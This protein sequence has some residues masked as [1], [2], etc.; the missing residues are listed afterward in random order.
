MHLSNTIITPLDALVTQP[1]Q[2][3]P[4]IL[5][6]MFFFL[7]KWEHRCEEGIKKIIL[8]DIIPSL[9]VFFFLYHLPLCDFHPTHFSLSSFSSRS[10][11]LFCHFLPPPPVSQLV[12]Y[13]CMSNTGR[14][15]PL[16]FFVLLRRSALFF[17]A[18][19]T[20]ERDNPLPLELIIRPF[21]SGPRWLA[22]YVK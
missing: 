20:G 8:A 2:T 12:P 3:S 10:L 11:L 9:W 6:C 18:K 15:T 16:L 7:K 14:G 4:F 5:H 13:R 21:N 1:A 22:L 19:T 17:P